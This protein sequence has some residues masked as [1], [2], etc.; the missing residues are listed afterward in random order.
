MDAS[1]GPT[2]ECF[3]PEVSVATHGPRPHSK[4][5]FFRMLLAGVGV[6]CGVLDVDLVTVEL[7]G[8]LQEQAELYREDAVPQ[9]AEARVGN[10]VVIVMTEVV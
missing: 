10:P 1:P 4:P 6:H 3:E 9:A 7:R 8:G 2:I 5:P